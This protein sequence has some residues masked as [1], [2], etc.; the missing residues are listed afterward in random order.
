MSRIIKPGGGEYFSIKYLPKKTP[1]RER[2]ISILYDIVR[3]G[4]D[5][6]TFKIPIIFGPSGTGKTMVM[7]KVLKLIK[8]EYGGDVEIKHLNSMAE[9][10]TFLA[11]KSIAKEI[12]PVPERG[13]SINEIAE[14]LYE[15]LSMRDIRYI[16]VLDDADE[17]I[18]R[19]R[20]K[21]IELLTR[22]EEE[23]YK[24]L[25]YLVIVLHNLNP[26][27]G[28]PDHIKSKIGG[29]TLEF[30]PY[31]WRQL[32]DIVK[33]RIELG[34]YQDSISKNAINIAAYISQWIYKGNAR[35]MINL[36]YRG[37]ILAETRG[38][39]IVTAEHIRWA[40]YD[41]H[42]RSLAP[43]L[44]EKEAEIIMSIAKALS[45]DLDN[46]ILDEET[47]HESYME[48]KSM[49]KRDI[50]YE[51]Y[52]EIIEEYLFKVRRLLYKDEEGRYIFFYYPV[53]HILSR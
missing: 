23:Y 30:K 10:K 2:E 37:G 48:Y 13:F 49:T 50:P 16:I 34:F 1:H 31:N 38:D 14:R 12:I 11:L 21:I 32:K 43:E 27:L 5:E 35:D 47:L 9:D 26:I 24:R 19:E 52:K 33:E 22:I 42:S 25:T 51:K 41:A 29:L 4:L 6:D 46:Y 28:L 20:G 53:T 8:E 36:V 18:R 17:L 7:R 40:L 44:R 3:R 45:K 39:K 15:A